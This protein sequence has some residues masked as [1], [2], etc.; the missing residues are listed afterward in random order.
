MKAK[1]L[2]KLYP[3]LMEENCNPKVELKV[4]NE[5]YGGSSAYIKLKFEPDQ[6]LY[7]KVYTKTYLLKL[8]DGI[9]FE[10]K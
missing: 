3:I 2:I 1:T 9:V 5:S 8:L 10:L 6:T 7:S 4:G